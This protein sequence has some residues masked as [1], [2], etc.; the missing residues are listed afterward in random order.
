MHSSGFKNFVFHHNGSFDGDV[1]IVNRKTEQE[2]EVPFED[3]KSF[4]ETL[5]K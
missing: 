1:I 4:V 5:W 2:M 3:L